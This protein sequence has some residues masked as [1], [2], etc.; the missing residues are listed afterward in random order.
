[1]RARSSGGSRGSGGARAVLEALESQAVLSCAHAAPFQFLLSCMI[2]ACRD[3][4]LIAMTC[5][6]SEFRNQCF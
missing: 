3:D 4:V 1:M 2:I 6:Q 5:W